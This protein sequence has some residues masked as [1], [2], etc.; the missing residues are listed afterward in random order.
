M[1]HLS[2]K[3][4]KPAQRMLAQRDLFPQRLSHGQNLG[5]QSEALGIA[6]ERLRFAESIY[7]L[8]ASPK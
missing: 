1:L 2:Y 8:P 5:L 4:A 7:R 3:P 6:S